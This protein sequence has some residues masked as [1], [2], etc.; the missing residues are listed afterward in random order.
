MNDDD[1]KIVEQ[2]IK[3]AIQDHEYEKWRKRSDFWSSAG[4]IALAVG[5]AAFFI[6]I[7]LGSSTVHL[8]H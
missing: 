1:R 8:L 5:S 4:P 7:V 2:M 6:G 3:L